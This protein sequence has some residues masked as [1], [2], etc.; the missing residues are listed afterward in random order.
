MNKKRVIISYHNL[1]PEILDLFKEKYLYGYSEYITKVT[2]PNNDVIYC[3][4]LETDDAIY[5]VKIDVKVDSKMSDE[6][7][8]KLLFSNLSGT[9][10]KVPSSDD[11]DEA[12]NDEEEADANKLESQSIAESGHEDDDDEE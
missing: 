2:K 1:A 7:F 6:D 11:I 9:G 8:D 4:P 3:V 12:R 10:V 5:M